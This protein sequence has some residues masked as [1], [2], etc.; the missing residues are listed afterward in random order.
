MSHS[1]DQRRVASSPS[2]SNRVVGLFPELLGVGGV[3]EAGRQTAAALD[4]IARKRG[5]SLDLLSLND[6][7]GAGSVLVREREISFH[8]FGRAKIKFVLAALQLAGKST[9]IVIAAHPHLALPASLMKLRSPELKMFVMS[10]GIEVWNRLPRLRRRALLAADRVLAPSTDTARKLADVQSI[11]QEKIR[12]LAWPVNEE[13]LRLADAVTNL[14][15][16]ASFPEGSIVLTVGRWSA[17][18]RYKGADYLIETIAQVRKSH[19]EVHLVA[20]GGGDDLPRLRKLASDHRVAD[21][22]TFLEGL[23]REQVAACY[24]QCD[25][26]ALPSTGE[27]FGI[28]FLEAMAFGKPVIGA[29]SGGVPDLVQNGVNGLLVPP[30]DQEK[31]ADALNLLLSDPALRL[32]L[33]SQG[34]EIVRR[35]Y[36]FSAFERNLEEILN[37]A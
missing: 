23:S 1:A 11:P 13:I 37:D 7:P 4:E 20:V 8:G 21:R 34:S 14:P 35:N 30:R 19:P 24:A 12:K 29:E 33:G 22:V 10:H 2:E 6:E 9:R 32:R 31:L 16:P 17:S 36:T 15:L 25:I 26:F 28:V 3:Q 18:E 27:G 5:W